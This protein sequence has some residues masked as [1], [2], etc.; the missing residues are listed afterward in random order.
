M[1]SVKKEELGD[2]IITLEVKVLPGEQITEEGAKLIAEQLMI[3][4]L[5]VKSEAGDQAD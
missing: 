1:V 5:R 3:Q 4:A 2:G